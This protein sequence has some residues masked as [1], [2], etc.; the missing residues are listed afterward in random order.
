M[1]TKWSYIQNGVVF[2]NH[3]GGILL[4]TTLMMLQ[5]NMLHDIGWGENLS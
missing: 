5:I 4:I 2:P 1:Y 3:N